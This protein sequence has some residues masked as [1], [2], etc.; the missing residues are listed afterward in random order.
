MNTQQALIRGYVDR[1]WHLCVI[2]P[3][4][5][6]PTREGWNSDG[7]GITN[8]GVIPADCNVGLLHKHSHTVSIDLD[9]LERAIAWL[10]E[11]G[12]DLQQLLDAPDAVQIASGRPNSSKLIYKVPNGFALPTK[13]VSATVEGERRTILEFRHTSRDGLTV[14]DVLPPSVHPSGSTY[15]WAGAGDWHNLPALPFGLQLLWESIIVSQRAAVRVKDQRPTNLLEVEAALNACDPDCDRQTWIELGMGVHDAAVQAGQP[16]AGF[17][18]WNEWSSRGSKYKPSEMV[19]QWRSFKPMDDGVHVA[20]VFYH[21]KLAGWQR[22]TPDVSSLFHPVGEPPGEPHPLTVEYR[23]GDDATEFVIDDMVC[24]GFVVLAADRGAGKTTAT[25]ALAC[26]AAWLCPDD[27]PLRPTI[28]RQVVYVTEH[29]QQVAGILNAMRLPESS[30]SWREWVHVIHAH[31]MTAEEVVRA[32]PTY[33]RRYCTPTTRNGLT[34]DAPPWVI[35]DTASA[36]IKL[37]E[38][39]SNTDISDAVATL[40]QALLA[41]SA[42]PVPFM[43]V[44]HVAK[45]IRHAKVEDMT[46]RGGGAWEADAYQVMYLSTEGNTRYFEIGHPN[47]KKRFDPKWYCIEVT[48]EKSTRLVRNR[49]NEFRTESTWWAKLKPLE[50]SEAH[51]SKQQKKEAGE[52]RKRNEVVLKLRTFFEEHPDFVNSRETLYKS[53]RGNRQD[54]NRAIEW[55]VQQQEL[56]DAGE[57]VKNGRV[58][59]GGVGKS[60]QPNEVG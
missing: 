15:Q 43:V 35:Y 34:F 59:S 17:D 7:G 47:A 57:Y 14:Q 16:E 12:V 32:V 2:P 46:M 44:G 54:F 24:E 53:I 3:G 8:A 5:K 19:S 25:V 42:R 27:D 30:G 39:N 49:F 60:P 31:R 6:G 4:M 36:V 33:L 23:G 11:R 55:M 10:A 13:R 45:A 22:P 56:T 48:G 37:N 9:H 20:T 29:P 38:E 41:D 52:Q 51:D 28:R 58:C 21:A 40:K 26:K 1:G 50:S 18:L